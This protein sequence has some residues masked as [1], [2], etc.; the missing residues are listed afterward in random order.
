MRLSDKNLSETDIRPARGRSWIVRASAEDDRSW[1]A[2]SPVCPILAHYQI[3]HT[4]VATMP[5]PFQIVRTQLG[6]S[7]FM[8]CFG[9]EGRV[10]VDGRWLRCTPGKAV[11]LPPRTLH[12]FHTPSGKTWEFCWVR[13]QELPGQRPLATAQS[14]VVGRYDA[15]P[16]RHAILGLHRECS[17]DTSPAAVEHWVRLLHH[18]VLRFAEPAEV[19]ER[20]YRLWERVADSLDQPWTMADMMRETHLSDKQLQRLCRR[21]L[22]RTPRQQLIWLRMR[23][24]AELLAKRGDKIETI[25]SRVGYQNPFVFSTTFKRVMGWSP[26]RYPLPESGS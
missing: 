19:D 23:R 16:L 21:Q 4:A 26:S 15:E 11:L 10:L 9:G 2:S 12:A 6:G 17:G 22:G 7:Y 20:L 1:L 5:A 13:Y 25:A 24:A 14:P 18:Y 3:Q 8:A